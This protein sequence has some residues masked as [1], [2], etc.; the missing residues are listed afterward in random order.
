VGSRLGFT[1]GFLRE[2]LQRLLRLPVRPVVM[3]VK[4]IPSAFEPLPG[5]ATKAM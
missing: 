2:G 5:I 1:L 3:N 4:T